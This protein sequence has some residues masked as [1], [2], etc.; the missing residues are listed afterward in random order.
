MKAKIE[1][2]IIDKG[3]R[4]YLP[5]V[6]FCKHASFNFSTIAGAKRAFLNRI[7]KMNNTLHAHFGEQLVHC[8][9]W[10]IGNDGKPKS[11]LPF[12]TTTYTPLYN[13]FN[14]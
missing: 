1:F 6:D 3:E 12:M 9:A 14:W 8:E 4:R 5:F 11:D 2:Y 10:W 7:E 13:P